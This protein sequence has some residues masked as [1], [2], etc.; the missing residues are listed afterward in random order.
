MLL[1]LNLW[2]IAFKKIEVFRSVKAG[3]ITSYFLGPLVSQILL[4]PFLNTLFLYITLRLNE[5]FRKAVPFTKYDN[6]LQKQQS[7]VLFK[8]RCS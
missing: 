8:K 5:T 6:T 4:G 1:K 2:E 7:K 3:Q